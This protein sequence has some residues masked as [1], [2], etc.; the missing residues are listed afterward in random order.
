MTGLVLLAAGASTRLGKPKQ[1]LY[2]EGMTL[3]ER[4]I[5]TALGSA[6]TPVVVVQRAEATFALPEAIAH[7]VTM[8]QN[9]EWQEGMASSIRC[10]LTKLL[11]LAP[12]V[13]AC[14]FMVCDQPFVQESLLDN[15]IQTKHES[16]K[17]IVASAY[18]DTIGTPV[19]FD[20]RYF[21]D[22]LS[23]QG[24]EGA[25]KVVLKYKQ[26]AATVPFP[27]GYID[28]DTA[29]DYDSLIN[30]KNNTF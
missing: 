14:I 19:L 1:E 26:D 20:K 28:I 18:K 22:L 6:C 5:K 15:M 27:L 9:P 11:A 8:V 13:S 3:F 23:L 10:G 7:A 29:E 16:R 30:L 21:P 12:D 25:K 2:F 17:G 4:A 24:Q